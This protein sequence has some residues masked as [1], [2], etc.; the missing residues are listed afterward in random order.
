MAWWGFRDNFEIAVMEA[1]LEAYDVDLVP[2]LSEIHADSPVKINKVF[3][4]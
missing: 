3:I 2:A 4:M 1:C